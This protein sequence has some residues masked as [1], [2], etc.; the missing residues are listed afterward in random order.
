ME[1][2]IRQQEKPR[3]SSKFQRKHLWPYLKSLVLRNDG[4]IR[5]SCKMLF[6]NR[7]TRPLPCARNNTAQFSSLL[8]AYRNVWTCA[9]PTAARADRRSRRLQTRHLWQSFRMT[10]EKTQT[11]K[12]TTQKPLSV[13][14]SKPSQD[15]ALRLR[16]WGWE[17]GRLRS[18]NVALVV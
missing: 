10:I 9:K 1:G 8:R 12:G 7:G 5:H 17:V 14:A 18:L 16:A 2:G 4:S 11:P 13:Q 15:E 3:Q 6:I